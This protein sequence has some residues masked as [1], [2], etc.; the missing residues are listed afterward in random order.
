M[1]RSTTVLCSVRAPGVIL[2]PPILVYQEQQPDDTWLVWATIWCECEDGTWR[3]VTGRRVT[4]EDSHQV[5]EARQDALD[6]LRS[7]ARTRYVVIPLTFR[8]ENV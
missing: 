5:A 3:H 1:R 8:V 6:D 2:Y 4:A 7:L